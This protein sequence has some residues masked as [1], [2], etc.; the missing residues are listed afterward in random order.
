M[1]EVLYFGAEWCAPCKR[2]GPIVEELRAENP[3]VTFRKIDVDAE[4][5]EAKT[6]QVRALP[7]LVY[8][9]DG[10]EVFRVR[11]FTPKQEIAAAFKL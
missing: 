6:Y 10:T 9:E 2:L 8:L 7:T 1:K 11:G 4:P 3:D 5:G